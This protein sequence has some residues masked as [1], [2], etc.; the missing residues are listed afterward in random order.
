VKR[1]TFDWR[2][3]IG[4]LSFSDFSGPPECWPSAN[5][6]QSYYDLCRNIVAPSKLPAR[7]IGITVEE[8][9]EQIDLLFY[10]IAN[11][12]P[13]NGYVPQQWEIAAYYLVCAKELAFKHDREGIPKQNNQRNSVR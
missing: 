5:F 3:I 6:R 8:L 1:C 11:G 2:T 12:Q 13:A 9:A 4:A 7:P 10:E